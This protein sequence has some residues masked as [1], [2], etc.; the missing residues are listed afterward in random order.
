LHFQNV[1]GSFWLELSRQ[2]IQIQDS[3]TQE[4]RSA[5]E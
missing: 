3:F 2:H 5:N 4:R 1:T